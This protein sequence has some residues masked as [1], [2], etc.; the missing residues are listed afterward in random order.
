MCNALCA[1]CCKS[2]D[3]SESCCSCNCSSCRCVSCLRCH[4]LFFDF[5]SVGFTLF[6][7]IA[8]YFKRYHRFLNYVII[9]VITMDIFILALGIFIFDIKTKVRR[10]T[11]S[12]STIGIAFGIHSVFF[13]M[14]CY[15]FSLKTG[16][17]TVSR[18]WYGWC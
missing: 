14:Y 6:L 2:S 18:Y 5:V 16:R 10:N 4:I 11:D 9:I 1:Q 8:T 15:L 7:H 3:D 17:R 12:C 13:C